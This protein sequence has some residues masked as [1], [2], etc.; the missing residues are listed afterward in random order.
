MFKIYLYDMPFP[1]QHLLVLLSRIKI[2]II[3]L[4]KYSSIGI[5]PVYP[6]VCVFNQIFLKEGIRFVK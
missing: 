4:K 5:N 3:N 2:L 1:K 6:K